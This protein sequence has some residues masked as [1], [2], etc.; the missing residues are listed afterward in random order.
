M[1]SKR[2]AQD[3]PREEAEVSC[4][5]GAHLGLRLVNQILLPWVFDFQ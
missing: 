2:P 3:V 1:N 4:C 5:P